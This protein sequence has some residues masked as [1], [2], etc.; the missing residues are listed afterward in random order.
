MRTVLQRNR[1]TDWIGIKMKEIAYK[2]MCDLLVSVWRFGLVFLNHQY[3]DSPELRDLTLRVG[4]IL[5]LM[6]IGDVSV[7]IMFPKDKI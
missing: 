4:K 5:D 7:E 6:K 2:F 1:R 3:T